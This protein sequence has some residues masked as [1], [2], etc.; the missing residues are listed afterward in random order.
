MT[1]VM[2]LNDL[3][4]EFVLEE[5]KKID[6]QNAVVVAIPTFYCSVGYR[7]G[8]SCSLVLAGLWHKSCKALSMVKVY[9]SGSFD[10]FYVE[11]S[12]KRT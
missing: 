2:D 8:I 12:R 4:A 6:Q 5:H 10:L 11:I 1:V 7:A 3:P 9:F